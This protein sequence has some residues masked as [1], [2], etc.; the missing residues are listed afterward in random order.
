MR[1]IVTG[2][3]WWTDALAI[4]QELINAHNVT[5]HLMV[6]H[7][8]CRDRKGNPMGADGIAD[9]WVTYA[10]HQGWNVERE[11]HPADWKTYS[12]AAGPKR[13]LEMVNLG[14]WCD[15]CDC[16]G[17][18]AAWPRGASPG[19]RGCMTYG[20]EAKIRVENFSERDVLRRVNGQAR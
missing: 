7:G 2:S 13:N 20:E 3:R 5:G 17:F 4:H 14:V 11:P 8:D 19:T 16:D 12:L 15:Q 1:I 6:V 10:Q 9:A 18:M